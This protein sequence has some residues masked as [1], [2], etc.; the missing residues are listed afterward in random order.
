MKPFNL[1]EYLANPSRKLVTKDGTE[2]RIICTDRKNAD[3]PICALLNIN[4]QEWYYSYTKD[5]KYELGKVT[6]MDLFFA[7]KKKE[8]WINIY[9]NYALNYKLSN[10]I[11]GDKESAI[12]L[13]KPNKDYLTTIK[14]EWEE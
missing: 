3:F 2:A 12:D 10:T 1:E 5:G 4:N 13:G 11:F 6:D 7:P 9:K 8:G 14:I